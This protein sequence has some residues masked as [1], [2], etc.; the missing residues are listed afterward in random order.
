MGKKAKTKEVKFLSK[1]VA[2]THQQ[3][4]EEKQAKDSRG[5]FHFHSF[6]ESFFSGSLQNPGKQ[7]V[8]EEN[9]G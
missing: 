1:H 4:G 7:P 2:A 6:Q 9:D 5:T 3:I 8:F